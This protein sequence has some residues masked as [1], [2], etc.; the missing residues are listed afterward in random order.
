MRI[1]ADIEARVVR[2]EEVIGEGE[3][4]SVVRPGMVVVTFPGAEFAMR[5]QAFVD[6]VPGVV[7]DAE[8]GRYSAPE[9]Y[10]S[11]SYR[12][13]AATP[14][15]VEAL[16]ED[17]TF[18]ATTADVGVTTDPWA[19]A[20]DRFNPDGAPAE[21]GAPIT[22]PDLDAEVERYAASKGWYQIPGSDKKLRRDD[23][24]AALAAR[25]KEQ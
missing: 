11:L 24:I 16:R 23:A 15:E 18:T 12:V 14:D 19:T 2:H 22:P 8:T 17:H 13:V 5:R 1:L 6:A 25:T 4:R 10:E 9:G 20:L 21:A 3:Q 7:L